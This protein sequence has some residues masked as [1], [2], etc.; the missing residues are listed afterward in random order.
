[1]EVGLQKEINVAID[2][3][4]GDYAPSEIVKGAVS[5]SKLHPGVKIILVGKQEVIESELAGFEDVFPAIRIE[6]ASEVV[7]MDDRASWSVKSKRNSSIA[8]GARLVQENV[9]DAFISAGNT[10]AVASASL[11]IMGRVPGVTRPAIGIIVPVP[12]RSVLLLDAGATADCKP[13]NLVQ[14]AKMA[15][16]YMERVLDI[17]NP[18]LGL[19]SIGEEKGKGN[20]LTQHAYSLLEK[21]GLNFAGNVEGQDIPLGKTDIVVCDGFTGNV[22]L[23]LM[24]GV[25]NFLFSQIKDITEQSIR[26]ELGGILLKPKLREL[27]RKLDYEEYGGA[28]LLGVDGV[29][30]I[31]HG[32]SKA[33]A[34]KNAVGVAAKTVRKQV[35]EEIK[36]EI[37]K[38]E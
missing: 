26:T 23:K 38:E 8:V 7:Y 36:K 16:I 27:K 37:A 25:V 1:M 9:A 29:C 24:E 12:K 33:K 35:V 18:S 17:K 22:V 2:V 3:M 5:A 14:F 28:Q 20:E 19:L 34:I 30:I 4:G 11:L 13:E 32:S 31:C 15:H 6:P 10:G 21:T